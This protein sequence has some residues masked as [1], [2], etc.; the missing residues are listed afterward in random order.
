[1]QLKGVNPL[2][3]VKMIF[4]HSVAILQDNGTEQN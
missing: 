1:M 3:K 2:L 4:D